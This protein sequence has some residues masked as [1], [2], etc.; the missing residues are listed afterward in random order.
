V[1]LNTEVRHM[2]NFTPDYDILT[3]VQKV[4]VWRT[5]IAKSGDGNDI[6]KVMWEQSLTVGDVKVM[7]D[8]EVVTS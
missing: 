8:D 6:A 2:V 4:E 1:V 5:A 7:T 3:T